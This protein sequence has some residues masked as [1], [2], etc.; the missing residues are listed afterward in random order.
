MQTFFGLSDA[1]TSLMASSRR[2][3]LTAAFLASATILVLASPA[4]AIEDG[5]FDLYMHFA[6]PCQ[7]AAAIE[8]DYP[9]DT[10]GVIPPPVNGDPNTNPF[11]VLQSYNGSPYNQ[12]TVTYDIALNQ[13]EYV[14]SGGVL[15][16]PVPVNWPGPVYVD[17]NTGNAEYQFGL[18]ID[19]PTE[20]GTAPISKEWLLS[21][22]QPCAPIQMANPGWAGKTEKAESF[23]WAAIFSQTKDT[24]IGT[25]S[26]VAYQPSKDGSPVKLS[27]TNGT[28]APISLGVTGYILNIAYPDIKKKCLADPLGCGGLE[29]DLD[30][31]NATNFPPPGQA[32]SP[33]TEVTPPNKPLEP[34]QHFIFSAK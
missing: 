1:R 3:V 23:L 14:L 27:L 34:G 32:G 29:K 20:Y 28:D 9:G 21:N 31:L 17:P 12:I 5:P 2:A 11:V 18:E 22:G 24:T 19:P 13:T 8:I 30:M 16:D 10:I 7:G 4:R 25:W 15:P 26:L 33:F 6:P